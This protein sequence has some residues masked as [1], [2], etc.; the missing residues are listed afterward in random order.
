LL[1]QNYSID[2][3]TMVHQT[4]NRLF[5]AVMNNKAARCRSLKA[6]RRRSTV[7]SSPIWQRVFPHVSTVVKS[8]SCVQ[9]FS[10]RRLAAL[11]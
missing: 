9:P 2:V 8:E 4:S 11:L 5:Q 6:A 10:D 1:K 3:F 7:H